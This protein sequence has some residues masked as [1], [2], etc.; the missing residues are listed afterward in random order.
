M[1]KT[2]LATAIAE[3][4]TGHIG[5]FDKG[6]MPYILHPLKVMHY[7]K[8]DDLELMA[9]AVLHDYV[10]DCFKHNPEAGFARLF[11]IGMSPRVIAGVRA[12]TK[13]AGQAPEVYLAGILANIDAIRVKLCDLRHNTD[14]RRLKSKDFDEKAKARLEKYYHMVIILEARLAELA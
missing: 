5:Q 9:I 11:E 8:T 12:L 4:A 13:I 6:G 7:L 1:K 2:M 10:E 14:T 3:A